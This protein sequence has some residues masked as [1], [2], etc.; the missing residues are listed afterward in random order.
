VT[1]SAWARATLIALIGG[2]VGACHDDA[3]SSQ[4]R[5]KVAV[6]SAKV[7]DFAPAVLLTGTVAARITSDLSFRVTGRILSRK[8]DIGDHVTAGQVLATLDPTEQQASVAAAE[9]AVRSSEAKLRQASHDFDRQ[10]ELLPSGSTTRPQFDRAQDTLRAAQAN[11]IASNAQL[12]IDQDQLNQTVLKASADGIITAREAEAGEVV[13]EAATVFSLAQDGARDAMFDVYESVFAR[14]PI[15]RVIKIALV[16]DPK[17]EARAVVREISPVIN[18]N[19]GTV[20][21]KFDII[22]SP[23]AMT[24]GA[25]V[26]GT[27]QF[28][29]RQAVMLPWTALSAQVGKPAV[30]LVDPQTSQVSLRPIVIEAYE[31]ER[32]AVRSGLAT[33][34]MVVTRGQQLLR[35]GELVTA[36]EQPSP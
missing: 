36:E 10:Q 12:G 18:P 23:P 32:I 11:L 20:R 9:A 34:A 22:D 3:P 35:P 19:N 14:K 13:Q 15:G 4:P 6:E 5:A 26:I 16:S 7:A 21:T 31:A 27:G 1:T 28:E 25:A 17:V 33:G 8:V 30:W 24:L 2:L 29:G